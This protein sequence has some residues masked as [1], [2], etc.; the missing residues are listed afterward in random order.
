LSKY[1]DQRKKYKSY[2]KDISTAVVHPSNQEK[3]G[4]Y[5]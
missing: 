4:P 5:N 1:I 2:P 3:A